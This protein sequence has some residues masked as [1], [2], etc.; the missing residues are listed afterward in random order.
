MLWPWLTSLQLSPLVLQ[1]RET[2]AMEKPTIIKTHLR[3]MPIIP[4]M[5]GCVVAVY[6]GKVFNTVSAALS[7]Q[8]RLETGTVDVSSATAPELCRALLN[9]LLTIHR[10]F[11]LVPQSA[12]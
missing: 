7:W 3:N 5:I 8:T 10:L 9:R 11:Y 1:K 12:G 2:K 4:E 6:N